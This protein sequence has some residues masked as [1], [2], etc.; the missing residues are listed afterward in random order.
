M[1]FT[2]TKLTEIGLFLLMFSL[3]S[4]FFVFKKDKALTVKA[5]VLTALLLFIF[6]MLIPLSLYFL[7]N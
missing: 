2:L 5:T 7:L 1:L 6:E 3:I 4:Y